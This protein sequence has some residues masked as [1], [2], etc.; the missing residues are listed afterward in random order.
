MHD[1]VSG[2]YMMWGGREKDRWSEAPRMGLEL[3]RWEKLG[4][5]TRR[6]ILAM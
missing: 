1:S 4:G 5:M 3:L 6:W 2:R